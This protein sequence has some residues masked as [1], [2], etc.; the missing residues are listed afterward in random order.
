MC[1]SATV[2]VSP[3]CPLG[4][5]AEHLCVKYNAIAA[6]RQGFLHCIV[7]DLRGVQKKKGPK[8]LFLDCL[9]VLFLPHLNG[10]VQQT[11]SHKDTDD[12]GDPSHVAPGT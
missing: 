9:I 10:G 8:P 5:V 3:S 2:S 12:G 1:R 6:V 11:H 4:Q 7:L